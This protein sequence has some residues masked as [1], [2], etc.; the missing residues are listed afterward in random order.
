MSIVFVPPNAIAVNSVITI[1]VPSGYFAS[2]SMSMVPGVTLTCASACV[3][4]NVTSAVAVQD[5]TYGDAGEDNQ[6][7]ASA[8]AELAAYKVRKVAPVLK[9]GTP[10]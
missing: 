3:G 8:D 4:V 9:S 10:W 5:S 6:F 7:E 2:R 1:T